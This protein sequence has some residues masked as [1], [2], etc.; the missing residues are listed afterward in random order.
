MAP[1]DTRFN[2]SVLIVEDDNIS[3]FV[4]MKMLEN[5]FWVYSASDSEEALKVVNQQDIDLI[6][7]DI[8]LGEDSI[9][10]IKLMKAI[11]QQEPYKS[12]PVFAITSYAMVEDQ[13]NFLAEGFDDFL[14]KPVKKNDLYSAIEHAM[15]K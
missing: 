15:S 9:D 10:G 2:S 13:A 11:R 3:L 7:M 1:N 8:N 4:L 6:L 5:D 14:P 12:V